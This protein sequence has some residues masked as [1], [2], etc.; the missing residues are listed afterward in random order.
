MCLA[1]GP[2]IL[3]WSMHPAPICFP[4]PPLAQLVQSMV[5][6]IEGF[7]GREINKLAVAWQAAAYGQANATLDK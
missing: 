1:G 4:R 6:R 5:E 7:S 3:F 2:S